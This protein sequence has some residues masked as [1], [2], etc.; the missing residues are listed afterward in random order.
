MSKILHVAASPRTDRSISRRMSQTFLEAWRELHRDDE[1]I[2]RDVGLRPPPF[3]SEAWI[4]E[5]GSADF[6]LV[7]TPMYNYGM[8]GTLKAWFDMVIRINK[9]ALS[10]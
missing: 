10:T 2:V 1:V 9:T 5:L 3:V 8:P 4:A 6:I 7:S